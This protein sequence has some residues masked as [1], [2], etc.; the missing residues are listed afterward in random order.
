MTVLVNSSQTVAFDQSPNP[1]H[2]Q[3]RQNEPR[4]I[5]Y[6]QADLETKISAQHV[7]TGM[8]KIEHAHHAEDQGQTAGQQK[9]Q[10]AIKQPVER[11]K[12]DQLKHED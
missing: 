10:Q 3:R 11:R 6:I 12:N 2:Q 5:A 7:K 8:G 1:T 9:Q 4:P